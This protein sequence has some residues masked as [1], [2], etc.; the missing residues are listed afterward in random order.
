VF[1][2][3][4]IVGYHQDQIAA[5][6][7]LAGKIGIPPLGRV[8]DYDDKLHSNLLNEVR[9]LGEAAVKDAVLINLG[10]EES[11]RF[12]QVVPVYP[13]SS[14]S[15]PM[16]LWYLRSVYDAVRRPMPRSSAFAVAEASHRLGRIERKACAF[17]ISEGQVAD[18]L[19]VIGDGLNG[20][21]VSLFGAETGG[22]KVTM[23]ARVALADRGV[24]LAEDVRLVALYPGG[25]RPATPVEDFSASR[26]TLEFIALGLFAFAAFQALCPPTF[27]RDRRA[28]SKFEEVQ[29][30]GEFPRVFEP[31]RA[32]EDI[33]REE[34]DASERKAAATRRVLS[35]LA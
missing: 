19:G 18:D 23:A 13:V 28:V 35:R 29:A 9:L 33:L 34:Q 8:Q 5:D 31:I 22:G 30:V 14:A 26:R 24:A 10:T 16:A 20:P 1:L 3:S 15:T 27:F 7:V 11:P 6:S 12:V 32:Q 25:K 17:L 21:L 4:V 2:L